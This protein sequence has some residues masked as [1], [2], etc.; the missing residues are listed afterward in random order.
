ME[1]GTPSLTAECMY[2]EHGEGEADW[3]ICIVMEKG[4]SNFGERGGNDHVNMK[5]KSVMCGKSV[6]PI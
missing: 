4:A 3:H 2:M 5:I 1:E 6:E